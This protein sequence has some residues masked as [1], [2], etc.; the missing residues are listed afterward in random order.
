MK[1]SIK[2]DLLKWVVYPVNR[3][4]QIE[5]FR[6]TIERI[7]VLGSIFQTLYEWYG[8]PGIGKSTLMYMLRSQ[9]VDLEVPCALID[10]R[11]DRNSNAASYSADYSVL[12][13]DLMRALSH[14]NVEEVYSVI[15]DYRKVP[16]EDEDEL[17]LALNRVARSFIR[18]IKDLTS[19]GPVVL[20]FDETE[21]VPGK[22]VSWLEEW[23]IAPL[24]QDG[25]CVIVWMGRRPQRWK[26][27]EVRRRARAQELGVFDEKGTQE[28]FKKN[29]VY[30]LSDLT[31]PV[32][33]LTGGHP[34][35][36]T[37]VL[38]HL[39]GMAQ[40]GQTPEKE[41]FDRIESKLLNDLAQKF[42]EDF[43]FKGLSE[44]VATACRLMS[45]VRQFDIIML[46]EILTETA[47]FVAEYR[48]DEFGN[49][50]SQLRGT[51]L[52]LWD[53]RRKGY[54]IDSTLRHIIG[55]HVR[56]Y[57][58]DIYTRVNFVA[59]Q[60]YRDW[61]ERAGDNR[62][63]YIVEELFQQAC[64]NQLSDDISLKYKQ[65]L[66]SLLQQRIDEYHQDDMDLRAA[67]LDRLYHELEDDSDLPRLIKDN[68]RDQLLEIVR[69]ERMS[70][71]KN[72]S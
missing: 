46:R 9:C 11:S 58:P 54:A 49:L 59:I 70:V 25:R 14:S 50:L 33:A 65:E 24:V 26:R 43:T 21:R 52:V 62:G 71:Y 51:Q 42:V 61:I 4:K 48:R 5:V 53:D 3:E 47:P 44:D 20:M 10:F 72:V 27:F 17:R 37:I 35:A 55:E 36:D 60:V 34:Y 29:S 68:G 8:S 38:R 30:P 67:A 2:Q 6:S 41:G 40:A 15:Q 23:I 16:L 39:D 69:A 57:S 32:H 7:R 56:Q 28:L 22:L 13:E 63:V 12:V 18:F 19:R 45:L 64:L 66:Q 1:P 31:V